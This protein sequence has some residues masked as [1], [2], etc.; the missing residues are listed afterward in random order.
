MHLTLVL[1]YILYKSRLIP[2]LKNCAEFFLYSL[3]ANLDSNEF[4]IWRAP[5][6]AVD[7][8]T[9]KYLPGLKPGD[10]KVIVLE[11]GIICT[12][13]QELDNFMGKTELKPIHYAELYLRVAETVAETEKKL[14][15][16]TTTVENL[17]VDS[18][19]SNTSQFTEKDPLFPGSKYQNN[20][21]LDF[22]PRVYNADS[23]ED[24]ISDD[25]V[26]I[27]QSFDSPMNPARTATGG[28]TTAFRKSLNLKDLRYKSDDIVNFYLKYNAMK[29][30]RKVLR[31]DPDYFKR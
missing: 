31:K 17:V 18:S 15:D 9:K 21:D 22:H 30:D 2:T 28:S 10:I 14:K 3:L 23:P 24:K 6:E 29:F 5:Q 1:K 4:L 8:Y 12:Y 20:P 16:F 13:P 19:Y 7:T 11:N 27:F 26:T 25:V